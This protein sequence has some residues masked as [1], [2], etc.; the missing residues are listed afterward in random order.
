MM[1]GFTLEILPETFAICRLDPESTIPSWANGRFL[2]IT[3]TDEELSI[4][5]S[6]RRVPADVRHEPGWR[7]F[8]VCGPLP[9]SATGV[10]ASLASPLADAG[11]SIFAI[12]TFD[13]DYLLVRQDELGEAITALVDRGHNVQS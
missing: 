11:I 7:C 6:Q 2:D 1:A 3:R 5:C 9:F 13:T 10:L 12:S 8:K 4:V